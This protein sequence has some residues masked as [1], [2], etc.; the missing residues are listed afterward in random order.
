LFK[1]YLDNTQVQDPTNWKDFEETLEYDLENNFFA[2][3]YGIDLLFNGSDAYNYL[4]GLLDTNSCSYT[5][6]KI[7]Q[8]ICGKYQTVFVGN[9]FL[10]DI[11]VD[12]NVCNVTCPV[13]ENAYTSFINNNKSIKVYID[14]STNAKSKN[15]IALSP[16]NV[17]PAVATWYNNATGNI[18]NTKFVLGFFI[19]DAFKYLIGYLSDLEVNFESNLLDYNL[20]ISTVND[21]VKQ[22]I[23][24]T[25]YEIYLG[26]QLTTGGFY[27]II[28]LNDLINEVARFYQIAYYVR[29]DFT[30]NPTFV[31]EDLDTL[32]KSGVGIEMLTIPKVEIKKATEI[33]YA[34]INTGGEYIPHSKDTAI[35]KFE[36]EQLYT[37]QPESYYIDGVCNIDR[38][39]DL[40]GDIIVDHNSVQSLVYN[41]PS[42]V[43]TQWQQL[44]DKIFFIEVDITNLAALTVKIT[45]NTNNANYH[46]N[47]NL[48]NKRVME[49]YNN[50]GK[51]YIN[52]NANV[53]TLINSSGKNYMNLY[54]FEKVINQTDYETIKA[55]IF[56]Q[57]RIN[58]GDSTEDCW[59]RRLSRKFAT[60]ESDLELR[61]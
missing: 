33:Y 42:A 58:V 13:Q 59:I 12:R 36:E 31:L 17:V 1:F 9:I 43:I 30:G 38:V 21:R 40:T 46:F 11:S 8:E 5:V 53:Y 50:L 29:Y 15:G 51:I 2:Y 61:N 6:L 52:S 41:Y 34:S 55:N 54:T 7:E 47:D 57:I 19:Y 37:F 23:M 25:G 10:S 20:P 56:Q 45:A 28:T 32:L 39:L 18:D 4:L 14:E 24:T 27:P 3:T 49:R 22:I 44:K 26:G 16:L 48:I 60:G 35:Y